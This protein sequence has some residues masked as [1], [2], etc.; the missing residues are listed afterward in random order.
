VRNKRKVPA[1]LYK[2]RSFSN[3]TLDT[4]IADKLFFADPGS[5]N[6]PLDTRP[7]LEADLDAAALADILRRLVEA[8]VRAEMSAAANTIKSRGPRTLNHIAELSRRSADQVIAEVRYNATDPQHEM[9]DPERFLF[10]RYVEEEL[11]RRYDKGI[12]SLAEQSDCPLMWSHYGDQHRGVCIGYSVPERAAESLHKINYGGSRCIEASSV[13]AMLD[14]DGAARRKV[15]EA[16]L[17]RKARAWRYEREWRL[18]GPRGAQNSPLELEEVVFGMRCSRAARYVIVASLAKRW[19]SVRFYELRERPGRFLLGKHAL[20]TDE[21]MTFP[22][23][24]SLDIWDEFEPIPDEAL[25]PNGKTAPV[26]MS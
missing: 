4:L 24:R 16:V 6:D 11:L 12:V 2:Y 23:R 3:L 19:R 14:G 18:I 8:R 9:E 13:A 7:V 15:D 20:D 21:M 1:G 22:P 10:G 5:F 25:Q 17:T 26:E